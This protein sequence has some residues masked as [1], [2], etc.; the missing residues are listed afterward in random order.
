MAPKSLKVVAAEAVTRLDSFVNVVTGLGDSRRDKTMGAFHRTVKH[1]VADNLDLWRGNHLAASAVEV[2][3]DE[4]LRP[5]FTIK[6]GDDKE[7]A[8]NLNAWH[9]QMGTAASV[10]RA[11]CTARAA[12]GAAIL[13]G[14]DDG[15]VDASLPLNENSIRSFTYLAVLTREELA[16]HTRQTDVNLPSFGEPVLYKLTRG[17]PLAN[18]MVR[19]QF[20]HASRIVPI[21]GVRLTDKQM[22]EQGGW[23]DSVLER[24]WESIRNFSATWQA[25]AVL[26][27]DFGQPVARI[28]G[29]MELIATNSKQVLEQ[30]M[31]MI[32]M[33]RSMCR[34]LLLDSD[35]QF[36]R[37]TVDLMPLVSVAMEQAKDVAAGL[38]IPVTLLM[39][40]SPAGLNATGDTEVRFFYSRVDALRQRELLPVLQLITRLAMLS[41]DGPTKGKEP[42]RWSVQMPPL[43][44][45]TEAEQAAIRLTQA[46]VDEKEI[47]LGIV[48]ATEIA[49]SRHGG[50]EW[51]AATTIDFKAGD[52]RAAPADAEAQALAEETEAL[53]SEATPV[54]GAALTPGDV[55]VNPEAVPATDN[56]LNGAQAIS[57]L[58]VV[59]KVAKRELP[60]DSGIAALTSIF[61]LTPE[62]AEGIMGSVGLTFFIEAT[63]PAAPP[64][65]PAE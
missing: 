57:L 58:A 8:E 17:T 16:V 10:H 41:K 48:N 25:I 43:W 7:Q 46:Q 52:S 11:F 47:N 19:E 36:E 6:T 54:A 62:Q 55:A 24:V 39:G 31:G 35:E 21:Y 53:E 45:M 23:G 4:M 18:G 32:E 34:M 51:S 42:E 65:E 49:V 3:P 27:Q 12:G 30:R 38:R 13:L 33:G 22:R 2:M 50:D 40:Q 56:A 29:L 63:P 61:K 1:S 64:A 59:D 60:R 14:C 9:E 5:G 15:A 44:Q 26:V 28:K 20:I 37:I